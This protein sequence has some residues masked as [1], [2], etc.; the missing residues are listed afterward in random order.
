MTN[1]PSEEVTALRK[2]IAEL[3]REP[4]SQKVIDGEQVRERFAAD[5]CG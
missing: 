1:Q 4:W 3:E 5:G 2:R